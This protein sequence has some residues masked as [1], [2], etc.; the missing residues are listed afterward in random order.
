MKFKVQNQTS[1]E[2]EDRKKKNSVVKNARSG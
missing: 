2:E 1:K